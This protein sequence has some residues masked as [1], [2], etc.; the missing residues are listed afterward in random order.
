M[1][2][3]TFS[4]IASIMGLAYLF[5]G[6]KTSQSIESSTDFFLAGKNVGIFG[7]T[8]SLIATQ[9]GGGS[10]L[11]TSQEAYSSGLLAFAYI[12]GISI[13]FILLA[14]GFAH[15]IRAQN[16]H[17]IAQIFE[18]RYNSPLLTKIASLASITSLGGILV[19][20]IV[21]SRA[22]LLSVDLY[23][24]VLFISLWAVV[25]TYTMMGGLKAVIS[26]NAFQLLFILVVFVILFFVDF[27]ITPN[28]S[29]GIP[30]AC[31]LTSVFPN[32][33]FR[34]FT[35]ALTPTLYALFEQDIAQTI[36]AAK[37][38]KTVIWGTCL[39]AFSMIAFAYIPFY[40]GI[41]AQSTPA[42]TETISMGAQPLMSVIAHKYGILVQL[43]VLYG[44]L[45]AILSTAN[46]LLCA[47]SA[48][49]TEDFHLNN[50]YSKS[51]A[52]LFIPKLITLIVGTIAYILAQSSQNILNI[53]IL[54][55]QIPV[56]TIF[57][58]IIGAYVLKNVSKFAAT[59][60][61]IIG[62]IGYFGTI[63]G[64][65]PV[66]GIWGT[67]GI[68]AIVFSAINRFF[69]NIQTYGTN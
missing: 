14:A 29:S 60:C 17:T 67:I 15:K 54:S 5:V 53:L 47:I 21:G 41:Q 45:A 13:G 40:F 6:Y 32:A 56:A 66:W 28:S 3:V 62:L 11:G 65:F 61:I 64:W 51:R 22:L 23:T 10:I 19:A 38:Q 57:V 46:S 37:N 48:H 36:I 1:E 50:I 9:L 44:I 43:F 58:P 39:A 7:L 2:L 52:N 12:T 30:L 55:Y 25:I 33:G 24:P 31:Q 34:F 69:P 63:I 49:V 42:L 59:C 27:F 26:N 35:V 8:M 20:Q 68:S 4:I 18:K 16:V